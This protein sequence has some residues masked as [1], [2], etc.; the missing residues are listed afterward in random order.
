MKKGLEPHEFES[1]LLSKLSNMFKGQNRVVNKRMK[2]TAVQ[3]RK[4]VC[5]RENRTRSGWDKRFRRANEKHVEHGTLPN[6]HE[7]MEQIKKRTGVSGDRRF[8]GLLILLYHYEQHLL[9]STDE[10]L[11]EELRQLTPPI[12]LIKKFPGF[13]YHNGKRFETDDACRVI[14]NF[15][16]RFFRYLTL[17]W[18]NGQVPTG[19]WAPQ[20]IPEIRALC[21]HIVLGRRTVDWA[22]ENDLLH[23]KKFLTWQRHVKIEISYAALVVVLDMILKNQKAVAPQQN[24]ILVKYVVVHNME[25]KQQQAVAPQQYKT[26]MKTEVVLDIFPKQQQAVA[27]QQNKILVKHVMVHNTIPE[28][29]QAVAPQQNETIV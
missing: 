5:I 2:E 4:D 23:D 29:Q 3:L 18:N 10:L 14:D 13:F 9:F 21:F 19:E 7:T 12:E 26:V 27:S 11:G 28:Q 24:E 22:N 1:I 17:L 8:D 20:N 25:P 6:Q 15:T 16:I